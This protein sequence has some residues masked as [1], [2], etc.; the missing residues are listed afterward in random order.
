MV[1]KLD[2]RINKQE[3]AAE[4]EKNG[5]HYLLFSLAAVFTLTFMLLFSMTCWKFYSILGERAD[6]AQSMRINGERMAA[7]DKEYER[8][9]QQSAAIEAKL[10]YSLGDVP[11]VEFLYELN[12]KLIDGVVVE[13]LTMTAAA[14]TIKGVAFADE[15][16]LQFSDDLLSAATVASVSL[17][18]ISTA[19]R[20]G[21]KLRAFSIELKLKPLAEALKGG[22][23]EKVS[24]PAPKAEDAPTPGES[25][26]TNETEGGGAQ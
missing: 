13:S 9:S 10:D 14:A 1:V 6:I 17:P 19:Q 3:S 7:M 26:K 18:A 21:V 20:N 5:R 15:E 2:L 12:N 24:A 8:L 23:I 22:G 4:Q 25:E 16:V 11:S